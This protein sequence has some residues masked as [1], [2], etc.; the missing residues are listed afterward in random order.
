MGFGQDLGEGLAL[1]K[2]G[3]IQNHGLTGFEHRH[4]EARQPGGENGTVAM[5]GEDHGCGQL[6][7]RQRGDDADPFLAMAGLEGDTAL[8][9]WTPTPGVVLVVIN[10]CF[11]DINQ[12]GGVQGAEAFTKD[13]PLRFIPLSIAITLFFRL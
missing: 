11:I 13:L 1:V 6:P 3:V 4:E 7:L 12:W 8:A 5:T 9:F 10:P 2:A